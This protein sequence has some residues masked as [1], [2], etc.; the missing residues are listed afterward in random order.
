MERTNL[1]RRNKWR[2]KVAV[3]FCMNVEICKMRNLYVLMSFDKPIV[4]QQ[5]T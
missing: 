4:V 5:L 3:R 2:K 1:M